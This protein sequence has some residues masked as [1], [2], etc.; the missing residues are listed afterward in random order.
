MATL[1]ADQLTDIR[2]VI[3]DDI[4]D[5]SDAQIQTQYDL[6]ASDLPLTYVYCLRRLWGIQRRKADRVTDHGDRELQS[7]V[8]DT[9]KKILDYWEERAGLF[10]APLSAGVIDLDMDMDDDD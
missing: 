8:A 6:A 1:T 9:T 10:G 7:Q 2:Q 4:S 3:G 5:L